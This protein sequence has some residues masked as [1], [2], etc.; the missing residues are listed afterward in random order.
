MTGSGTK[1]QAGS[2]GNIKD[3]VRKANGTATDRGTWRG[4]F[5]GRAGGG[6][7]PDKQT[8]DKPTTD[9]RTTDQKL[10]IEEHIDE[11]TKEKEESAAKTEQLQDANETTQTQEAAASAPSKPKHQEKEKDDKPDKPDK[12]PIKTKPSLKGKNAYK[13]INRQVEDFDTADI[14]GSRHQVFISDKNHAILKLIYGERRLSAILNV[15]AERH[16]GECK[17]DMLRSI[18]DKSGLF[19]E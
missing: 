13:E 1:I 3:L 15:L 16:I 11:T 10:T 9:N 4:S 6:R 2:L 7:P 5:R 17:D 19:D 14:K 12:K 8:S 18:S